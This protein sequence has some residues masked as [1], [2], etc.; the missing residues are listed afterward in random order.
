MWEAQLGV[1][2]RDW[3]PEKKSLTSNAREHP[4]KRK[5]QPPKKKDQLEKE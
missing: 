3:T 5:K 2:F 1:H 4:T